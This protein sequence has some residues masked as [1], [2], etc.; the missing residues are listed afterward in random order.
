MTA[1]VAYTLPIRSR[2]RNTT[3]LRSIIASTSLK[4]VYVRVRLEHK[5]TWRGTN[6]YARW[7]RRRR[8][9]V[10][11]PL[12]ERMLERRLRGAVSFYAT[13]LTLTSSLPHK[14]STGPEDHG[15]DNKG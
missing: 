11:H 9:D 15:G 14:G 8:I 5:S 3:E 4:R 7:A 1:I 13:C 10:S 2:H 6:E 12:P